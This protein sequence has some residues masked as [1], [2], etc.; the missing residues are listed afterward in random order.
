MLL[1]TFRS[2]RCAAQWAIRGAKKKA[3]GGGAS[4]APLSSDIVNIF[5]D[6]PDPVIKPLDDYP[7]Y[8]G[9]LLNMKFSGDDVIFQLYRGERLPTP[10]E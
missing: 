10:K 1:N 6:R 3:K 2:Q 8:L 9:E 7:K 4:E 5:K